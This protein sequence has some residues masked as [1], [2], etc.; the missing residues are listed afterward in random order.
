MHVERGEGRG[1][2]TFILLGCR[3]TFYRGAPGAWP[4]GWWLD[5]LITLNA[6]KFDGA[7]GV[8]FTQDWC[9]DQV[10]NASL[11]AAAAA[12]THAD[13]SEAKIN[14]AKVRMPAGLSVTLAHHATA[15]ATPGTIDHPENTRYVS[16]GEFLSSP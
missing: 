13:G 16:A 15:G 8:T 6:F 12:E 9:R 3:G 11:A 5:G 10:Y 7:G 4:D 14:K 2:L 1:E